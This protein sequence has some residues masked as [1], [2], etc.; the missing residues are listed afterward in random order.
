MAK[1]NDYDFASIMAD[2][3]KD[4]KTNFE[5]QYLDSGSVIMNMAFGMFFKSLLLV[6]VTLNFQLK[7]WLIQPIN[8]MV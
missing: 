5:T 6:F 3:S 4:Y 1:T 7:K 8:L 2:I